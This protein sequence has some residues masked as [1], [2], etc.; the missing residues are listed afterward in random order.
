MEKTETCLS[1]NNFQW[2]LWFLIVNMYVH[3]LKTTRIKQKLS[4]AETLTF[5]FLVTC[6]KV[7]NSDE[8]KLVSNAFILW[9]PAYLSVMYISHT[10]SGW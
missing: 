6:I 2:S 4:N 7:E 9:L 5:L 1:R 3:T 8:C 10:V